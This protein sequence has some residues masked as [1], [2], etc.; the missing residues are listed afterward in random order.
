M[1][2]NAMEFI[3]IGAVGRAFAICECWFSTVLCNKRSVVA[4]RAHTETR[5]EFIDHFSKA[6]QVYSAKY[7]SGERGFE[8]TLWVGCSHYRQ[9][10]IIER[11][12][13]FAG[14]IPSEYLYTRLC[15]NTYLHVI[16]Q[17]NHS[18]GLMRNHLLKMRSGSYFSLIFWRRG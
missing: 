8:S 4:L 13:N 15:K 12:A 6:S 17:N 7:S 1:Q 14:R 10:R 2:S 9:K 16:K 18:A 3:G 11:G 5:I